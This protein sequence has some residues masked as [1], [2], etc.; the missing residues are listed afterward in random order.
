[1]E[2]TTPSMSPGRL[3]PQPQE[4]RSASTE[5]LTSESL[6][7]LKQLLQTTHTEREAIH[8][9]VATSRE[10]NRRASA[11]Y[12]SWNGG[13]LLKRLFKK[14]FEER[15]IMAQTAADQLTE[16]EEQLRLTTIAT[17][18]DISPEQAEPFYR[19]R[20]DFS[21]L[22]E[23]KAIWDTLSRV[24][25]NQFRERSI[26]TE[27]VEREKVTFLLDDCDLLQWQQKVPR[28]QNRTG[29]DLYL[30]PGFVIYRAAKQ[31]FSIID[32][33]EVRL[34]FTRIQFT[35]LEPIPSDSQIVGNTWAKANKDG[36]PDRRFAN[37][38]QIPI[39]LYGALAFK[40]DTGLN[41]EFQFS[42]CGATERFA[43][44]WLA[45]VDSFL[46]S[47][48]QETIKR[49]GDQRRPR[50]KLP[51]GNLTFQATI[52]E[53]GGVWSATSTDFPQIRV[54]ASTEA[55]VIEKLRVA[56]VQAMGI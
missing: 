26:S 15:R 23:C 50:K 43:K 7:E 14:S 46:P 37:N 13:F 52:D 49:A 35:E 22:G 1:M 42:N 56:I 32:L 24:A 38:R 3:P 27:R 44:S 8:Q 6:R 41:E 5:L 20:D 54:S 31:A 11:R 2:S 4:I 10:G 36:G 55:E 34:T 47:V 48:K 30:Y 29:G 19:M 9:E 45:F 53:E 16:M 17:E 18:I 25:V 33:R 12:A 39:A 21:S 28:L 51:S 40:T